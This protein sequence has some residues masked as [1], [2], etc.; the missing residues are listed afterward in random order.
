MSY[1]TLLG[2]LN[3]QAEMF[4]SLQNNSKNDQSEVEIEALAIAIHINQTKQ[5]IDQAFKNAGNLGLRV[6][7]PFVS[8]ASQCATRET[9]SIEQ[10]YLDTLRPQRFR[11]INMLEVCAENQ[12]SHFFLNQKGGAKVFIETSS[13]HAGISGDARKQMSRITNEI[14][15]LLSS[16]PVEFGSSIFVCSDE[17]R[18]D[19]LKALIIGPE[20]TPY[21]N[22]CFEFD[23]LL[24]AN[25]PSSPP[26]VQFITTGGGSV[27]FN[28]NLYE[29]GKVCLSLLGT[30]PGP[31]WDPQTS[32]IL[33]VLIS[34]QSLILVPDP[35]FNEPGYE[36][37]MNTA[38]GKTLSLNY[39]SNLYDKT[40]RFAIR[41]QMKSPS[42]CFRDIIRQHFYLKQQH[43][44][45][46]LELWGCD[47][48][49]ST[50]AAL[51]DSAPKKKQKKSVGKS[52]QRFS[53]VN[54]TLSKEVEAELNS[55]CSLMEN[56]K[57]D[58]I[59]MQE[60]TSEII[61]VSDDETWA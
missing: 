41:D 15:S 9:R 56:E 37:Q 26:L 61:C 40:L 38:A 53:G 45:K 22:G 55:L 30:W 18:L 34:I 6:K 27:R 48:P 3:A 8:T 39:N 2:V 52:A 59:K 50:P 46:Q 10:Q 47:T 14:S 13:G 21:E 31:G 19:I 1:C 29:C 25:Y 4:I 57:S 35:Y 33:Q 12:A 54:E 28:P 44:L 7:R 43:I 20:G 16:L 5:N 60:S 36:G 24:P 58:N 42:Y 51:T 32:T 17:D 23:I 49:D 11:T